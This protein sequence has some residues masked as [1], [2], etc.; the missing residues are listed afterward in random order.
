[1]LSLSEYE[2]VAIVTPA[3]N[4]GAK[5][6]LVASRVFRASLAGLR[7]PQGAHAERAILSVLP[8]PTM[9]AS[10]TLR[11][12]P[13]DNP[14]L[15]RAFERTYDLPERELERRYDVGNYQ[16]NRSH[17]YREWLRR[18]GIDPDTGRMTTPGLSYFRA[19]VQEQNETNRNRRAA[20]IAAQATMPDVRHSPGA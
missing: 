9:I 19:L 3:A 17:A 10:R 1:M 2:R 14:L 5:R 6:E 16:V 7:Y 18:K 11:R 15:R 13:G 12:L 8:T 20:R 4:C